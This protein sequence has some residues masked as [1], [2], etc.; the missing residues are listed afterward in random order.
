MTR[1][2]FTGIFSRDDPSAFKPAMAQA[3]ADYELA[4]GDR[5]PSGT[6]LDMA[7]N[8]P[9]VDPRRITCPALRTA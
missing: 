3:L 4:L 1:D 7:V 2:S 9:V 6:Y 8:M 5:A